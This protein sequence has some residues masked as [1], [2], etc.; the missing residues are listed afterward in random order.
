MK[1]P[2]MDDQELEDT[3]L[4]GMLQDL[5]IEEQ[6]DNLPYDQVPK[7]MQFPIQGI[8]YFNQFIFPQRVLRAN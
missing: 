6:R 8:A 3:E 2:L 1:N 5:A 7:N 4:A